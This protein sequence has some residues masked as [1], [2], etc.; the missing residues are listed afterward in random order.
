MKRYLV[1]LACGLILAMALNS[2][3]LVAQDDYPT[4]HRR[5]DGQGTI[6]AKDTA[7]G[8]IDLVYISTDGSDVITTFTMKLVSVV[9][10]QAGVNAEL[11]ILAPSG[12][13]ATL[14][15]SDT[16]GEAE[17]SVKDVG[18]TFSYLTLTSLEDSA[19][20]DFF[21]TNAPL[22]TS[23]FLSFSIGS[24]EI[25]G[26]GGVRVLDPDRAGGVLGFFAVGAGD[27]ERV[28]TLGDVVVFRTGD[29]ARFAAR[30][31]GASA[32]QYLFFT[33][34]T[35]VGRLESQADEDINLQNLSQDDDILF[36][37]NDG[38]AAVVPLTI[39]GTEGVAIAK[40]EMRIGVGETPSLTWYDGTTLSHKAA[41]DSNDDL[42]IEAI[43]DDDG[44]ILKVPTASQGDFTASMFSRDFTLAGD[45][46][47]IGLGPRIVFE[48]TIT[49]LGGAILGEIYWNGKGSDGI[50]DEF[51]IINAS[52]VDVAAG[53]E[54]GRIT[55]GVTESG[56]APFGRLYLTNRSLHYVRRTGDP[57][58]VAN[59]AQVFSKDISASAELFTK[60]EGGT[61]TRLSSHRSTDG[62]GNLLPSFKPLSEGGLAMPHSAYSY[63]E[64]TGK[65]SVID[66]AMVAKMVEELYADR[67]GV[68]K[69][70]LFE[71][72]IPVEDWEA[73]KARMM[74][75]MTQEDLEEEFWSENGREATSEEE[76]NLTPPVLT[77]PPQVLDRLPQA[78]AARSAEAGPK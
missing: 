49:Q 76:L 65:A 25:T 57:P 69:Q 71:W 1:G 50:L 59:A 17:I 43:R 24:N 74:A 60:N 33:D 78:F 34:T 15:L 51:A 58:A 9:T 47:T 52:A 38:G 14:F 44:I 37:V 16:D 56:S 53:T 23:P 40:D 28:D 48:S 75:A 8:A 70:V 73:D 72:D 18:D 30:T 26:T 55:F 63:N 36:G 3:V 27:G 29:D 10:S 11:R 66:T 61:V 22:A 54:D 20:I 7:T 68:Q 12:Q 41:V 19:G 45:G 2:S 46:H 67:F 39:D 62:D 35:E 4:I 21:L 5:A 31:D 13:D 77:L 6:N 64:Y 42:T 32:R